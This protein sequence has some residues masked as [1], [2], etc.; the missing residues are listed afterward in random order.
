MKYKYDKWWYEEHEQR[1]LKPDPR[2]PDYSLLE[3][4]LYNY[5]GQPGESLVTRYRESI[6]KNLKTGMY[7]VFRHHF[8]KNSDG[9]IKEEGWDEVIA[10]FETFKDALE[11]G[12]KNAD[13]AWNGGYGYG[14]CKRCGKPL[15]NPESIRRGYGAKCWAIVQG[16]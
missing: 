12:E 14:R 8:Y 13:K 11:Y 7:E 4:D 10:E 5:N 15:K 3:Y 16:K 6:R 9:T 1:F 2:N